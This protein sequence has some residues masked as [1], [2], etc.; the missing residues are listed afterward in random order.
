MRAVG[1][2]DGGADVSADLRSAQDRCFARAWLALQRGRLAVPLLMP[3]ADHSRSARHRVATG[4]RSE[5][6]GGAARRVLKEDVML[7]FGAEM[8][9][10]CVK[11]EL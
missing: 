3:A 4:E 8:R 9:H 7:G 5:G 10:G 6:V 1:S 11:S 2:K